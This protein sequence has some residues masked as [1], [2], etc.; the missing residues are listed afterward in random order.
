[1]QGVAGGREAETIIPPKWWANKGFGRRQI[2]GFSPS[3]YSLTHLPIWCYR[4]MISIGIFLQFP[5]KLN[6]WMLM[7]SLRGVQLQVRILADLSGWSPGNYK[8]LPS[9]PPKGK[10][11]TQQT[12]CTA[13]AL[14]LS[15]GSDS[16]R[17]QAPVVQPHS[18][19]YQRSPYQGLWGLHTS[20]HFLLL[21][22]N[23]A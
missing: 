9:G 22:R 4:Q 1:M 5:D 10:H 20:R 8:V 18:Y 19:T 11:S 7:A 14:K 17:T 2:G 13:R 12:C 15:V 6:S 23:F 21:I 3:V 16:P